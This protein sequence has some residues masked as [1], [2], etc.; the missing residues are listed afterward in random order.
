M[1]KILLCLLVTANALAS[2][3]WTAAESKRR[4]E[5]TIGTIIEA[6]K[7]L[8]YAVRA[9]DKSGWEKAS[10]TEFD[11]L[12]HAFYTQRVALKN[13]YL[14]PY[15]DCESALY[16]YKFYSLAM[17]EKSGAALQSREQYGAD[18]RKDFSACRKAASFPIANK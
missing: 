16:A 1:K 4:A 9:Q 8:A 12:L 2:D 13:P 3:A 10:V 6:E 14:E 11:R 7:S 17:F 18:F 5:I 15:G